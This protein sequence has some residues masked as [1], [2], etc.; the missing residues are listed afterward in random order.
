M[1]VTSSLFTALSAA[2]LATAARNL[3]IIAHQDDD[4]LFLNPSLQH[5]IQAGDEIQTVYLTAGDSGLGPDYWTS[6]QAGALAAYAY[7]AGVEN[8]WDEED[9]GIKGKT[10]P[11]YTLREDDRISLAFLHIPD[12][13][14]DGSGFAAT[15]NESLE[16]LWKGAIPVVRTVDDSGTTYTRDELIASLARVIDTY[17]PDAI[18]SLD[19]IHEFGSGD[20]SDHTAGGLFVNEGATKSSF[21]GSVIAYAGYPIKDLPANVAGQDLEDKK[22]AFYTYAPYDSAACASDE[23]CAGKEYEAWLLREYRLN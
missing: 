8:A 23:G 19:Y 9:Y 21:G 16:K 5:S 14:G 1:R 10:I 15:G 2:T 6:R 22:E 18:S 7:M 4:L 3:N 11:K 12:G 20:H 13:N 17:A